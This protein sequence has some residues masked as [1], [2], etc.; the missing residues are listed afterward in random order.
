MVKDVKRFCYT[1]RSKNAFSAFNTKFK[2]TIKDLGLL[3]YSYRSCLS[4]KKCAHN[5]NLKK[6]IFSD[7]A[8]RGK[9]VEIKC[10]LIYSQVKIASV[11]KF[12]EIIYLYQQNK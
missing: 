2:N 12:F 5:I 6:R 9:C 11:N 7:V 8:K 1:K 3:D 10:K 4:S